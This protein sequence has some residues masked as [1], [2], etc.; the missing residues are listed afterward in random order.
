MSDQPNILSLVHADFGVAVRSCLTCTSPYFAHGRLTRELESL[1][2]RVRRLEQLRPELYRV[3][4]V[5]FGV[6]P[7]GVPA[8]IQARAA[9]LLD[10]ALQDLVD[11]TA[12]VSSQGL[13]LDAAAEKAGDRR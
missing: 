11:G 3:V 10:L 2:F 12:A 7:A 5:S 6:E 13:T 4:A 9:E 8:V 1:L